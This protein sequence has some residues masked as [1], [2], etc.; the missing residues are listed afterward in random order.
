MD[1][2][3]RRQAFLSKTRKKMSDKQRRRLEELKQQRVSG[4]EGQ[5]FL[6]EADLRALPA[7]QKGEVRDG[8]RCRCLY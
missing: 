8:F 2:F 4:H 5:P 6:A 1:I 7:F 3:R